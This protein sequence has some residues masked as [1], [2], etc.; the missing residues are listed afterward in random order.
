MSDLMDRS[1][2]MRNAERNTDVIVPRR[3]TRAASVHTGYPKQAKLMSEYVAMFRFRLS[4]GLTIGP[5]TL[6]RLWSMAC[7]S[8]NVSVTRMISGPGY[9]DQGHVYSLWAVSSVRDLRWVETEME[10]LLR[11]CMPTATIKLVCLR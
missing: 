3:R 1:L 6:R 10:R 11:S 5:K 7:C 4:N 2:R 9:G 8:N